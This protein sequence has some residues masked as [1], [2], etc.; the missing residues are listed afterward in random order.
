MIYLWKNDEIAGLR[1][2][3][4]GLDLLKLGIQC[5]RQLNNY[6]FGFGSVNRHRSPKPCF[7]DAHDDFVGQLVPVLLLLK[8]DAFLYQS[9]A[10]RFLA[11]LADFLRYSIGFIGPT[12]QMMAAHTC[13]DCSHF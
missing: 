3:V 8:V 12:L 1:I 5:F 7:I 9:Q 4:W 13:R 6:F 11:Q 10:S 2:A